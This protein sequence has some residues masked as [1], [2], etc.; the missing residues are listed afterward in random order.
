ER[1]ELAEL[2][3]RRGLPRLEP[4]RDA[5]HAEQDQEKQTYDRHGRSPIVEEDVCMNV[6]QRSERTPRSIRARATFCS[7][8]VTIS[9]RR[10][11]AGKTSR[12]HE[13]NAVFARCAALRS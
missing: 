8:T 2:G 3:V 6:A 9:R 7:M 5:E 13:S 1:F 10:Q 12:E 11:D 4:G